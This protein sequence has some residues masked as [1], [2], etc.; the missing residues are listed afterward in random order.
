MRGGKFRADDIKWQKIYVSSCLH[1][2]RSALSREPPDIFAR[3]EIRALIA[4][5]HPS[6]GHYT[7]RWH[8]DLEIAVPVGHGN[9]LRRAARI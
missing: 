3:T 9:K 4:R 1:Q 7:M 8:T 2:R 5:A 6:A